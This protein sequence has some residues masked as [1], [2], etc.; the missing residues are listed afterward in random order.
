[1][2]LVTGIIVFLL[3]WWTS[4]F[5]VLPFGHERDA[6]GTPKFSNMKKKF[7]WTTIV[8]IILWG[9]VFAL[10]EADI[11]SFREMAD[12]MAVSDYVGESAQ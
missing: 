11:V 3:I 5:A 7:L 2:G 12:E 8:A 10:I 1:M 6:D 4:L 9:I